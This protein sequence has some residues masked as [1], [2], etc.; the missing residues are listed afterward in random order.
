MSVKCLLATINLIDDMI[1]LEKISMN[2][3]P[4]KDLESLTSK[5][6]ILTKERCHVYKVKVN[7]FMTNLNFMNMQ[8]NKSQN[9][10]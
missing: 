5:Q 9:N 6:V 7:I 10:S 3:I 4:I 1:V 8:R 2:I